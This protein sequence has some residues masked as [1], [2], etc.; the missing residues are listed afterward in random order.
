M[1]WIGTPDATLCFSLSRLEL[2]FGPT[3]VT[4]E[5]YEPKGTFGFPLFLNEDST[6]NNGMESAAGILT[7]SSS[8]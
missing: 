1:I 4:N 5:R 7:R 6:R 2:L 8:Q 3:I